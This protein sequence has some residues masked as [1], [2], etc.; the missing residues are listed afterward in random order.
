MR[1]MLTSL[2]VAAT[3]VL[4]PMLAL[5]GN[6]EFAEQIAKNLRASGQM[7]DYKIGVMYQDGTAW[8][9]GQVCSDEQ[10]KTAMQIVSKMPGVSRV[11]NK[12]TIGPPDVAPAAEAPQ[13]NSTIQFSRN[14][15]NLATPQGQ[16]TP[17]A[18]TLGP[19]QISRGTSG[20]MSNGRMLAG[21]SASN[22]ALRLQQPQIEPRSVARVA[23][24]FAPS[25]AQ[26]VSA[27][28]PQRAIPVQQVQ[29][30]SVPVREM[31]QPMLVREP[32]QPMPVQESPQAVSVQEMQ[33]PVPV[34]QAGIA[35]HARH[36]AGVPT[37]AG[38]VMPIDVAG[39][40]GAPIPVSA[41]CPMGARAARRDQPAMPCHAW[42]TYAS[43][44]NY[45]AVTYPRQYSP[46]AWPYIGPFYPYPQVPLGWRKV[47]LEWDDGWWMLDFKD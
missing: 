26:Q 34:Q 33:Q 5:A 38:G 4:V 31:Q 27:V 30:D 39:M 18:G 10:A 32:Q 43:Y 42:P 25:P 24:S 36:A 3:T 19:E 21:T 37:P 46:T 47:T 29:V 44:P 9:R 6:Q 23:T 11:E 14:A 20:A 28:E 16:M 15:N 13:A 2:V 41:S 35:R 45:S 8:L 7:H 1:R 22:S 12:L 40:S 17:P